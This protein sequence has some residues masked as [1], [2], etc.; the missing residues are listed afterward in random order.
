[1]TTL[2][3]LLLVTSL[4]GASAAVAPDGVAAGG[5]MTLK[6]SGSE[7]SH[8][9]APRKLKR[10]E[11]VIY[12]DWD[13]HLF[14]YKTSSELQKFVSFD[15]DTALL[16]DKKNED[17]PERSN[18]QQFRK[19]TLNKASGAYVD[20]DVFCNTCRAILYSRTTAICKASSSV[21]A[22]IRELFDNAPN[23]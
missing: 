17:F 21:P 11:L 1:V 7:K 2:F 4:F 15:G 5:L 16:V 6:C 12:A 3:G 20:Y 10:G 18:R 14:L 23:N 8:A 9:R 13:R 19:V 22:K